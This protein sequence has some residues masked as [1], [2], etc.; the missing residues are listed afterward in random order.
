MKIMVLTDYKLGFY[1]IIF[2]L[3]LIMISLILVFKVN[4]FI[5]FL[6]F[7]CILALTFYSKSNWCF[8]VLVI[9][10]A[11]KLNL[12]DEKFFTDL[13]Y[14]KQAWQ[15]NY[16]TENLDNKGKENKKTETINETN[17]SLENG[18]ILTPKFIFENY[19]RSENFVVNWFALNTKILFEQNKRVL[20]K[21]H[22][23]IYPDGIWETDTNIS[24]LE[25]KRGFEKSNNKVLFQKGIETLLRNKR[26]YENSCKS[27]DLYL[28]FVFDKNNNTKDDIDKYIEKFK[29]K[30]IDNIKVYLFEENESE[31]KF[32]RQINL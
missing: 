9:F 20:G 15:G 8:L 17:N 16:K 5:Q 7:I 22:L 1:L 6:G 21:K 11:L 27:I 23:S 29:D 19:E 28:A 26:F 24:I 13:S 4:K 32:L 14:L 25:V 12:L 3:I 30:Y 2:A 31:I 10:I 18:K